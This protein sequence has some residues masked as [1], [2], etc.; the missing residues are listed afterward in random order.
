MGSDLEFT[1]IY[2]HVLNRPGSRG[3][4]SPADRLPGAGAPA[5]PATGYATESVRTHPGEE[6]VAPPEPSPGEPVAVESS[7]QGLRGYWT[8]LV[9]FLGLGGSMN[10]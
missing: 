6:P 7:N 1:L 9:R 5:P 10:E 2:T 8:K 4:F 3:V